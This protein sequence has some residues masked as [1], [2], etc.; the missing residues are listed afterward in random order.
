MANRKHLAKLKEGVEAWNQWRKEGTALRSNKQFQPSAE[1]LGNHALSPS[2]A[3]QGRHQSR[4]HFKNVPPVETGC[5]ALP[6]SYP[7]LPP[8]A[9]IVR[10]ARRLTQSLPLA[11][12]HVF[13]KSCRNP[14]DSL[15]LVAARNCS[16][17]NLA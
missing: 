2:R 15:Y 16:F 9:G 6:A 12:Q 17:A 14:R 13:E 10:K 3:L 5:I 11:V 7:R 4:V 8:W 1:A